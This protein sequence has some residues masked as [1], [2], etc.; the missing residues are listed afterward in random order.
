MVIKQIKQEIFG[1]IEELKSFAQIFLQSTNLIGHFEHH[2]QDFLAS[3]PHYLY[4]L[5]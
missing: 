2:I 1:G 4:P 5:Y 3:H